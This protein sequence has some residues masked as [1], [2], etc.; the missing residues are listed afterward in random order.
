M[1]DTVTDFL[2]TDDPQRRGLDRAVWTRRAVIALLT[3]LMVV[4]LADFFGQHQ[5]SSTAV[6]PAATLMLTAPRAVRG[7]LLFQARVDVIAR[8]GLKFP[9]LLLDNG[10]LEGM[11]VNSIEPQPPNEAMLAGRLQLG[12]DAIPAGQR[13]RVYFEFQVNPTNFG[14]HPY[15]IVLADGNK[16]VGRVQRTM[17]VLP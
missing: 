11:Q 3:A 4:A 5:S 6:A 2:P 15:G 1:S 12:Y 16:P 7:G 14:R 13:L 8:Q 10:W 9:S 17:T